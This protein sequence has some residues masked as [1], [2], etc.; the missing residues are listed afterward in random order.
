MSTILS[1]V[2]MTIAGVLY[3]TKANSTE[4][5]VGGADND[6]VVDDNG[7]THTIESMKPGQF[8]T[9]LLANESVR[10]R[11]LQSL[12]D[13]TIVCE[14]NNGRDYIMRNARCGTARAIS[15]GEIKATFFGDV[16]EV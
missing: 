10:L 16:E 6:P 14:G 2:R 15:G 4:I 3:A 9:I 7:N 13:E 11:D 8:S 5:D 1:R 12:K